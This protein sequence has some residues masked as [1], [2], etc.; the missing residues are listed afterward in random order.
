M[1]RFAIVDHGCKVNRYD[2]EVIRAELLRLGLVESGDDVAAD[3]LVLNACAVTDR[4]VA[5]G[6]RA[7]R[8]LRRRNPGARLVVTGCMTDDDR[9]AYAALVP[10][11]AIVPAVARERLRGELEAAV[12]GGPGAAIETPGATTPTFATR[13][14]AFVKVVDGCDAHCSFCVIPTVRGAIRSREREVV[15]SEVAAL[16]A[17]GIREIVVCG[18]HLGHYGRERHSTGRSERLL[19]LLAALSDPARVPGDFRIR[20][21]SLEAAEVDAAFARELLSLPRIVPHLH[22]PLQSGDDAVLAAMRRPYTAHGFA[23]RVAALRDATDDLA[24]T[25]DV[26]AGFPGESDA[27]AQRSL[28]LIAALECQAVHVFP[29]SPRAGTPAATLPRRVPPGVVRARV[30]RL[31]ALDRVLRRRAARSRIGSQAR[32]LVRV[33]GADDG[34]SV[35]LCDRYFT[36]RVA[37]AHPRRE[38][39]AC[40]ILAARGDRLLAA[41][42]PASGEPYPPGARA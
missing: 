24:L 35:G 4:A 39:V 31:L 10:E 32:V 37:G 21:G 23:R 38:F 5:K 40:R 42:A 17:A 16:V 12:V 34:E 9:Q 27:A 33:A 15:V 8:A 30:A 3:L 25:T 20:L 36:V 2:G 1:E 6:R 13:T 11:A 28:D 7:L 22:L 41:V 26:I 29:Y 14:R 19:D 18:V